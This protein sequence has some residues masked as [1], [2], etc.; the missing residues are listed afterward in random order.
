MALALGINRDSEQYVRVEHAGEVIRIAVHTGHSKREVLII[1]EDDDK[2]KAPS[3]SWQFHRSTAG[4]R[5]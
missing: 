5:R 4:E 1:M 3:P 2:G